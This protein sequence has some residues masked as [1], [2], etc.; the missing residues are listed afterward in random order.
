MENRLM[1]V[2]VMSSLLL[3]AAVIIA[4]CA[5][6]RD[7]GT[8]SDPSDDSTVAVEGAGIQL[9]ATSEAPT[10]C[11]NLTNGFATQIEKTNFNAL[12]AASQADVLA[13][14]ASL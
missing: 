2:L 13:F 10:G 4:S 12:S 3:S 8:S 11:D 9:A 14:I 7:A 1:K 5:P 6:S